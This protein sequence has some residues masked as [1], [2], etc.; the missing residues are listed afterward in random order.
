MASEF[1]P[2]V[3]ISITLI[4][5]LGI[6]FIGLARGISGSLVGVLSMTRTETTMVAILHTQGNE[7][8]VEVVWTFAPTP[9][10][11]IVLASGEALKP[12]SPYA[13]GAGTV[14]APYRYCIYIIHAPSPPVGVLT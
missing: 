12:P 3:V 1:I 14:P 9:I 13:C 4:V 11:G 8:Y 10:K 2:W 7:Y 5:V 6:L